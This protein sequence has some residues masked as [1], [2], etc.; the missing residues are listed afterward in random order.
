M[1]AFFSHSTRAKLRALAASFVP[2]TALATA[3]QWAA[4]EAAVEHAI[5]LRPAALRRQLGLLIRG[6][7]GIALLR[8]GRGV[9]RLDPRRRTTL[10]ETLASSRWLLLRRGIW[11]LRTL[12]MLGWYTQPSVTEALGYRAS[13]AGWSARR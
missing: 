10:L 9:A 3:Q 13:P 2:E 1:T 7:D 5:A 11:G 6:I 12:V 8:Y 4:F